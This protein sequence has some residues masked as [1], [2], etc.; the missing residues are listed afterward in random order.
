[1]TEEKSGQIGMRT[2]YFHVSCFN[3]IVLGLPCLLWN[4]I[5]CFSWIHL[6]F[7]GFK[8]DQSY[9]S[10]ILK[11]RICNISDN[12]NIHVCATDL[13]SKKYARGQSVDKRWRL[14]FEMMRTHLM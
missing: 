12:W 13:F 8:L 2:D 4:L 7:V 1:M 5:L 11:E 10:Y 14:S 3:I 6:F 9:K